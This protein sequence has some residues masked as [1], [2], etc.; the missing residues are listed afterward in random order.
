MNN[1]KP[2][3]TRLI[4]I[5]VMFSLPHLVNAQHGPEK[6]RLSLKD[7]AA[8]ASNNNP[9]FKA[10]SLD[11]KIAAEAVEEAKLKRIPQVYADFNLQRN[12]I[13]PI[14]PVPSNAFNPN[15]P[16]GEITPL[17]FNTKWT[18]NSGLNANVDLFN[19]QKRQDV[20]VAKIQQEISKLEQEDAENKLH[21]DVSNAY[22]QALI[23]REQQHLAAIDTLTKAR[24]SKM[25]KEQFDA[26]RITLIELQQTTADRNNT[27]NHFEETEK[28]FQQAQAQLLYFLGYS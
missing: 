27:L 16:E 2:M 22:A 17:R 3:N 26:G 14:T 18:A 10:K 1:Q 25:S 13:I 9:T 23:A 6:L 5:L 8:L 11:L 12:L 21:F 7:A 19:P 15:A 24:I 28:I 4:L 20:K